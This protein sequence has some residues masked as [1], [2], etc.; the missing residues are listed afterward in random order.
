MTVTT[1]RNRQPVRQA[2]PV[3]AL[4]IGLFAGLLS[5]SA[6]AGAPDLRAYAPGGLAMAQA[7]AAIDPAKQVPGVVS[8]SAVDFKRG[9]GGAGKLILRFDGEGA[10]PDLRTQGS[11]IVVNIGNATLPASLQRPLNVTDFATPVQR[12]DAR[13]GGEGAQLVLSTQGNF[14]S[15]AYQTGRDYVVEIVPRAASSERAVGASSPSATATT[16]QAS[17]ARAYTGRPVTFNFQDVPVRTVLQLIAEESNLNIVASDTVTGNVTLRLINVPW[18][19]AMD[20][21]L[22]ARQLDKRRN[23]NVVWVAPQAEI[24]S[25]GKAKKTRAWNSRS[26]RRWSPSTSRSAT[27]MPR[28]SPSC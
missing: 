4:A 26:V 9:D 24:A 3:Q 2:I 7:A 27:A 19:Q 6:A 8:V 28:T 16:A 20:I 1:V 25:F 18:D 5:A 10:S 12:I 21:V 11:S 14:E 17:A 23:G 15:M 22:Q 13:Q